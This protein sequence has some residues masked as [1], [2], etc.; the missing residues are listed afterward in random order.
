[1]NTRTQLSILT[2]TCYFLQ[3]FYC[4]SQ[5]SPGNLPIRNYSYTEYGAQKTISAI[6]QDK[7]GV[8]YFGNNFGVLEYDG[9][10]W[11]L[12]ETQYDTEV[13]SL[14]AD[15]NGIIYVGALR[16]M[17]YLSPDSFGKLQFKS[18]LNYLSEEDQDFSYVWETIATREGVYFRTNEK[19]FRW[20]GFRSGSSSNRIKVWDTETAFHVMFYVYGDIYVRQW[21]IGLMKMVD[22]SLVLVQGGEQF[23]NIRIYGMYPYKKNKILIVTSGKGL[24]IVSMDGHARDGHV[25]PLQTQADDFLI[26]NDIYLG[27]YIPGIKTDHYAIGSRNNGMV[28]INSEGNIIRYIN[29]STG[30]NNDIIF[31]QYL[32]SKN[33]LWLALDNGISKVDINSPFTLFDKTSGISEAIETITRHNGILFLGGGFGVYYMDHNFSKNDLHLFAEIQGINS[34]CYDLLSVTGISSIKNSLLIA[35]EQGIFNLENLQQYPR[36]ITSDYTFTLYQSIFDPAHIFISCYEGIKSIRWIKNT[37]LKEGGKWIDE[38][39]YLKAEGGKRRSIVEDNN[40]NV[41]FGSDNGVYILQNTNGSLGKVLYFDTANCLPEG[42]IFVNN[43]AGK[44]V[45][46]TEQG[47][48]KLAPSKN[49]GNV[50]FIPDTTFG[51]QFSNNPVYIHRINEDYFRNVWLNKVVA[52]KFGIGYAKPVSQYLY[53]WD[54]C[55]FLNIPQE[56]YHAIYHDYDS[57]TWL[58][59]DNWL[60]RYDPKIKYKYELE[61]PPLIRKVMIE[62]DSV[63]FWGY[64]STKNI[65]ILS[66]YLQQTQPVNLKPSLPYKYN[67][68]KIEFAL[69][70]YKNEKANQYSYYL[71]GFDQKWSN[72]KNN[73]LVNYTNLPASDYK[74]RLK[75][76]NVYKNESKET[77]YEFTIIPPFYNTIWFYAGQILFILILFSVA[78]YYGRSGKSLRIATVLATVSIFIVFEYFQTFAEES[79]GAKLGSIIFIKVLLNVVLALTLLPVEKYLKFFLTTEIEQKKVIKNGR[80]IKKTRK[81]KGKKKGKKK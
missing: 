49:D 25:R 79:L 51:N 81:K 66:N 45:F 32:D 29:E 70:G 60:V 30:I 64:M 76:R 57:T 18:L 63:I 74:F 80:S 55:K 41:W 37:L 26:N 23:A 5:S 1:M 43:I 22:D 47:L 53:M 2:F 39:F 15:T 77:V 8:M 13:K 58:G 61:Y 7:R 56:I 59:G 10:Q 35:T 67:S 52:K 16:E 21:E 46:A 78:F 20:N 42:V 27:A 50:S 40:G 73:T 34:Y 3:E 24:F 19:L 9:V 65:G 54:N 14:S 62:E 38:G 33:N 71:E 17:G 12:I 68:I 6:T 36:L 11:R 28:I 75:A 44:M 4:F 72:W 31:F 48:Y 69:P